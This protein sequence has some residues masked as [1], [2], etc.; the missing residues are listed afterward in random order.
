MRDAEKHIWEA[1]QLIK[2]MKDRLPEQKVD[3]HVA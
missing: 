1:V 3:I 2:P